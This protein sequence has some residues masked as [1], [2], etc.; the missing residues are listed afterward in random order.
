MRSGGDDGLE[1][2]L[3]LGVPTFLESVTTNQVKHSDL[4]FGSGVQIVPLPPSKLPLFEPTNRS[5]SVASA[6]RPDRWR[7]R[8]LAKV[9]VESDLGQGALENR[10]F[11]VVQI[12]DE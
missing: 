4:K 9:A 5:S 8:A 6:G 7:C 3:W 2:C 10:E 12:R 11:L 1:P